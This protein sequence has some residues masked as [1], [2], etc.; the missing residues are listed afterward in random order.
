MLAALMVPVLSEFGTNALVGVE[1]FLTTVEQRLALPRTFT[2]SHLMES[3]KLLERDG[4]L[5]LQGTNLLIGDTSTPQELSK[6][7]TRLVDGVVARAKIK[8][9][10]P[11]LES[12]RGRPEHDRP[13]SIF[14]N[15][16]E[17]RRICG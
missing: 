9:G 10:H 12:Q 5:A 7:A 4:L 16:L 11:G 8:F 13:A 14:K 17:R 2:R 6:D 15:A 3:V 1:D